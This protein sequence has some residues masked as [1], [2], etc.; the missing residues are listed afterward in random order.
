M[1]THQDINDF[2]GKLAR[3]LQSIYPS[4]FSEGHVNRITSLINAVPGYRALM[5]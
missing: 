1:T 5:E 2:S 3:R 4:D